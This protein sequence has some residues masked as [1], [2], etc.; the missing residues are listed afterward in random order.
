MY[1]GWPSFCAPPPSAAA[2]VLILL[3][4][5]VVLDVEDPLVTLLTFGL[6]DFG[7]IVTMYYKMLSFVG[8]ILGVS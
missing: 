1:A 5:C 7:F 8:R 6:L 3:A 2:I 4:E